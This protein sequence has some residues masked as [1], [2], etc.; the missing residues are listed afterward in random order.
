MVIDDFDV[1]GVPFTEIEA[2]P[3]LIVDADAEAAFPVAAERFE[4]IGRQFHQVLDTGSL[5]QDRVRRAA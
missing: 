3:P 5:D 2:N 1:M 4:A